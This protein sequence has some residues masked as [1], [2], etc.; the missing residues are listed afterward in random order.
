MTR[1][2]PPPAQQG[3]PQGP[4]GQ[5]GYPPRGYPQQGYPTQGSFQQFPPSP[6]R[7]KN[8][9]ARHKITTLL[10]IVGGAILMSAIANGSS[11]P[12]G[13]ASDA[14]AV[15]QPSTTAKTT[16]RS[17]GKSG[18][19][20]STKKQEKKAVSAGIGDPVRAGDLQLTAQKLTCGKKRVG[21]EY[22]GET[23][24]GQFCIVKVDL[25]NVGDD[26]LMINAD[27]F[28]LYDAGN[29]KFASDTEA[30]IS[31]SE[32]SDIWLEDINPGNTVTGD[33]IFDIPVDTTAVR[34]ELASSDLFGD[35]A[36][37]NLS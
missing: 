20:T 31:N 13:S 26:P 11:D 28:T 34:M 3:F 17:A 29:R 30:M 35:P 14:A 37:I 10:V 21:D 16:A 33:V 4:D 6:P 32:S 36:V 5:Q 7:K 8:W 15:T 19:K 27:D 2:Q 1:N 23:A 18:G 22:F 25:S 9:F 24:Q 12:A